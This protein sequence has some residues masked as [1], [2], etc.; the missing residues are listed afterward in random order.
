M[1]PRPERL[2]FLPGAGGDAAFWKPLADRLE[3]RGERVLLGWPGF[4]PNAGRADVQS[5][6][7]LYR[8][9]VDVIDRPVDLIAQSMGGV[10]AVRAA[11]DL[12]ALVCHLVLAA[13]SGGIDVRRFGAADWRE[14]RRRERPDE[15]PWFAH[16]RTDLEA[17]LRDVTAPTLLLWGDADAVSPVAVGEHLARTLPYA[18]LVVIPGGDHAF[19]RDRAFEIAPHVDRHVSV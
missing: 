5:L 10:L 16:D 7:D 17:R 19:A 3:H 4:G 9:V 2:V 12:P 1:R 6:D 18:H 15:P 13:T 11:L 8:L 14:Q